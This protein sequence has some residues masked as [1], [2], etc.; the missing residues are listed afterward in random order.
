MQ[1]RAWHFPLWSSLANCT[2]QM[3]GTDFWRSLLTAWPCSCTQVSSPLSPVP[4]W[5]PANPPASAHIPVAVSRGYVAQERVI[6][7]STFFFNEN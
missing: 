3:N 6:L 1:S 7:I 2:E 4:V 5:V